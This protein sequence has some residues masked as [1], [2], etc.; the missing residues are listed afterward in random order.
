MLHPCHALQSRDV[1]YHI[2]RRIGAGGMADVYEATVEGEAGFRRKVA[3]TRLA[4]DRI[5]DATAR[6]S[7]VDEARI[8]GSL[9]HAGIVSVV[10]Y[11]IVDGSPVQVLEWVDGLDAAKLIALAEDRALPAGAACFI[12]LE[13]ARALDYAHRATD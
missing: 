4:L 1:R 11:G 6:Q 3:I 9:H 2:E 13:V 5:T 12:A 10:D 8:A 7:F